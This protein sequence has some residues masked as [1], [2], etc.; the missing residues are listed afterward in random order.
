MAKRR[1]WTLG[2]F[3]ELA[4]EKG[5]ECLSPAYRSPRQKLRF[6][7][8]AGHLFLFSVKRVA[9]GGW[10]KRCHGPRRLS[11]RDMQAAAKLNAGTCRSKRYWGCDVPLSWEC[12]R[13]HRFKLAPTR[14]RQGRW[15]E[16]CASA[17]MLVPEPVEA[18][19]ADDLAFLEEK[20]DDEVRRGIRG[21]ASDAWQALFPKADPSPEDVVLALERS[22]T[23]ARLLMQLGR[24]ARKIVALRFGLDEGAWTIAEIAEREGVT[25]T[26]IQAIVQNSLSKLRRRFVRSP[27]RPLQEPMIEALPVIVARRR[28]KVLPAPGSWRGARPKDARPGAPTARTLAL[29]ATAAHPFVPGKPDVPAPRTSILSRAPAGEI[30]WRPSSS[31]LS[32]EGRMYL[33]L[34]LDAGSAI[35]LEERDARS[36]TFQR[37]RRVELHP[38]D[39]P[40]A[41]QVDAESVWV[42]TLSQVLRF[43]QD[44]LE[45]TDVLFHGR[46]GVSS[47]VVS[48]GG[49]CIWLA[50]DDLT[51]I[52]RF[53]SSVRFLP[54]EGPTVRLMAGAPMRVVCSSDGD[55]N[56][57]VFF[58]G[59][60]APAPQHWRAKDVISS[61]ASFEGPGSDVVVI[62]RHGNK[63]ML[64]RIGYDPW[65]SSVHPLSLANRPVALGRTSN[66]VVVAFESGLVLGFSLVR[67]RFV[68]RWRRNFVPGVRLLQEM[69][70]NFCVAIGPN[71]EI[72]ELPRDTS[73]R[74]S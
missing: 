56:V 53:Q 49:R 11:L 18:Q 19:C 43:S 32:P 29:A 27:V 15:C 72:F 25:R 54:I 60:A 28:K 64:G 46:K 35:A 73:S 3:Q 50:G 9:D 30:L 10:C 51:V 16:K 2:Q 8:G 23:A 40:V 13:G 17:A 55:A 7:C 20:V 67:K 39:A 74:L 37:A 57:H 14:V 24:R 33:L 6:R 69:G 41:V 1:A 71:L 68:E 48:P 12:A 65:P 38:G 22:S 61:V 52:D 31:Q 70:G 62:A 63:L 44:S 5:G 47:A 4:R 21:A 42:T 34:K 58:A 45:L 26:R 66:E 36:G 59:D